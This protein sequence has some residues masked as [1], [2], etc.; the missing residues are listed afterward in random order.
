MR[1]K[2]WQARIGL[3]YS[4]TLS[5]NG[6][7]L[8]L[9]VGANAN[10]SNSNSNSFSGIGFL[11]GNLTDMAFAN[12]YPTNGQPSGSESLSSSVGVFGNLI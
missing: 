12:S 4:K 3:T 1:G 7:I 10:K 2:S 6:S 11:K 8:T 5:D 9:N